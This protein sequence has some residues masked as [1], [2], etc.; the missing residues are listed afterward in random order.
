MQRQTTPKSDFSIDFKELSHGEHGFKFHVGESLFALYEGCEVLGGDCDCEVTLQKSENLLQLEVE[1]TGDVEVECDRCLEPCAVEIDYAEPLIVKFS[2]EEE[3][4]G[5]F[6]GEVMWLPTA[7]T[8]LDLAQYIYESI[9][10]S[11]PYQR[12]HEEGDCNPE[13]LEQFKI[14]TGEE[15]AQIEKESEESDN[16]TMPKEELAKLQAL[17]EKMMK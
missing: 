17:K 16:E 1:I 10:L 9:I 12:V 6:D 2:D 8:T 13:M 15:F 4:N 3:L 7:T 14:V 11:L 5:E